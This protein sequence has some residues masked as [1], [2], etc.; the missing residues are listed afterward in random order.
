VRWHNIPPERYCLRNGDLV[1]LPAPA[2]AEVKRMT[3]LRAFLQ[4]ALVEHPAE[5]YVLMLWG[6][7]YGFGYGCPERDRA[8]FQEL[9][10]ALQE[11]ARQ[12]SV[13]KLEILV[14]NSCRIGKVETIYELNGVVRYL[15]AS[16]VGV[17]YE[18][19]PMRSVFGELV[20]AP[21]MAPADLAAAMV[22]RYCDWYRQRTVSMTMIDLAAS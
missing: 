21:S 1:P 9:A 22:K 8:P 18:G 7:A 6:H 16:Q 11:F 12:R 10:D 13:D 14:C 4:D 20:K 17:P 5:H 19:F 3:A 15:V 2:G